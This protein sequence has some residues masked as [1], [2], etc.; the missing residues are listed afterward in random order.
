MG[1]NS[2]ATPVGVVDVEV[3]KEDMVGRGVRNSDRNKGKNLMGV[4]L[5]ELIMGLIFSGG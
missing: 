2:G 4:K 3:P 1:C 5:N